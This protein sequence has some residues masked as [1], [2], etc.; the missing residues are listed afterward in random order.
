MELST[1][2]LLIFSYAYTATEPPITN[3]VIAL[4][5]N[6]LCITA[7]TEMSNQFDQQYP[8]G[9]FEAQCKDNQ[10]RTFFL[11]RNKRFGK[12]Q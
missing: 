11:V 10:W 6:K 4:D 7:A 12:T 1:A 2:T 5:S 8:G 9:L 3:R